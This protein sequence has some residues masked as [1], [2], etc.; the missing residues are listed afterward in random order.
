MAD[1]LNPYGSYGTKVVSL[2]ARLLFSRQS[3]SLTDLARMLGCSKQTVLRLIE[4]IKK[5]YG[6]EI[7]ERLIDR[8][9]YFKLIKNMDKGQALPL[10]SE[11]LA[12]LRMCK[13]FT[14]H[15]LGPG[16][17]KNLSTA[18]EKSGAGT[19]AVAADHFS[20]FQFG[21]IDYTPHQEVIQNV[22]QA[23]Q[24]K[25]ICEVVY[26]AGHDNGIK[27]FF[28]KPLRLFTFKDTLYLCTQLARR[29]GERLKPKLFDPLL[30]LHR[31]QSLSITERFFEYP[32][33]FDFDKLF[34]N[35]FG[36][37]KEKPFN[38][39]VEFS[40]WAATYVSERVWSIDQK[41]IREVDGKVFLKLKVSSEAEFISWI[42]SF[43]SVAMLKSPKIVLRRLQR[44]L[45][46]I[47]AKY[48][49]IA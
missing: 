1:K 20:S 17:L 21:R 19:D 7:E 30:A 4:D 41:I 36:L 2:F 12:T 22:V 34:K 44:L 40:G 46:S 5:G 39:E 28:I 24:Q 10:T 48:H 27:Q 11:E 38:A 29:P 43:G 31:I 6:V 25:R 35:E 49:V 23:M 33:N 13:S 16:M 9:K 3:H 18:I 8:R 37:M 32:K 47:N 14:E 26:K 45:V 42:L 15:L